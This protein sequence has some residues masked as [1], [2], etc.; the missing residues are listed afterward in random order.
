MR[1]V[2]ALSNFLAVLFAV[3]FVIATVLVLLLL[4]SEYT[5]LNAETYKNARE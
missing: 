2:T 3:L 5:L 1:T 4:N